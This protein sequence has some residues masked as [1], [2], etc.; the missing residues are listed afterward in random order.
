MIRQL[1]IAEAERGH[2]G[3]ERVA[4]LLSLRRNA[5]IGRVKLSETRICQP[6]GSAFGSRTSGSCSRDGVRPS[7]YR[8][9]CR[10]A[11]MPFLRAPE[12]GVALNSP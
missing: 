8:I 7:S 1:K 3:S 12:Y 6:Q 5:G 9:I 4:D 11:S 10:R 2:E